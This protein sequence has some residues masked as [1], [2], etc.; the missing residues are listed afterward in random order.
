ME[1]SN[2]SLL[3]YQLR[4]IND[5]SRFKVLFWARG[6]RKS[7][8]VTLEI[9]LSILTA[10]SKGLTE[11]WNIISR[12]ERQS[13]IEIQE[14]KKHFRAA[15]KFTYESNFSSWSEQNQRHL[16]TFEVTTPNGSIVRA[17]PANADTIRGYSCNIYLAE[18]GI[19]P[20]L[21]SQEIWQAAYPCLRGRYRMIVAST[22]KWKGS[23]FH[24][25]VTDAT[26]TWALHY[27]DIYQA[28][29]EG[30]PFDIA[31]ERKALNDDDAWAQE[32]ELQWIDEASAW[33]PYEMLELCQHELAGRP[34]EYSG[35]PVYI[36]NDI[37]IRHDLWVAWVI[38]P[39]GDVLWTR[40]IIVKKRISFAEQD[41]ILDD[42]FRRYRVARLCIDQTGIGE[43]PVEDAKKRYGDLRVEGVN[44]TV[45]IKLLLATVGKQHFEQQRIRIPTG[46]DELLIDFHKLRKSVT[47]TGAAR[48]IA[49]STNAGHADRVW[50][51]F[52]A[53]YAAQN[54]NGKYEFQSIG[55]RNDAT[56]SR[57]STGFGTIRGD[58]YHGF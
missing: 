9:V 30:L 5:T 25:I 23:R 27:V 45:G 1:L 3:P 13:L 50:A 48:F 19:F 34:D 17:L 39:I 41:R 44:F 7:S 16:K 52:L 22:G 8:T 14:I 18:Y 55:R 10:E 2:L 51:C 53:L 15:Q 57:R 58:I 26:N 33:L 42:L 32:Y 47:T 6:A 12:G 38:E 4:S 31:T 11:E 20:P 43:K 24:Q 29:R 36:G 56:T 54:P 46:D 49:E 35:Q 21:M 40:E 28:V 37:A